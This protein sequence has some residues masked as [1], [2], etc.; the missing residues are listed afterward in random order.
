[1]QHHLSLSLPAWLLSLAHLRTSPDIHATLLLLLLIPT[2]LAVC[3]LSATGAAGSG[4]S[5]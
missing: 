1:M 5:H 4:N 2:L 3:Q